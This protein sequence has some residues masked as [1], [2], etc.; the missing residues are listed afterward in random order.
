MSRKVNLF[1]AALGNPLTTHNFLVSCKSL[2]GTEV[3]MLVQSTSFPSE[4]IREIVL[5]YLGERVKY[6]TIPENSGH[7]PC[8]VVDNE[9]GTVFKQTIKAK[10]LLWEQESGLVKGLQGGLGADM[11][12][13]MRTVN[14]EEVFSVVMHGCFFL[15]K[16]DVSLAN[17]DP[18]NPFKW[19][20]TFAYDWISD[21][22]KK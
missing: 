8:T 14:D 21:K 20:L 17:N 3:P 13:T 10:G 2:L 22:A 1:R 9:L 19:N 4:R 7:W 18:T 6:P 12:V 15:G 5:Y 16:D 11:D